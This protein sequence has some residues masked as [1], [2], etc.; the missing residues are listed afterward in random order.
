MRKI[1]ELVLKANMVVNGEYSSRPLRGEATLELL[2]GGPMK[3]VQGL[4]ILIEEEECFVYDIKFHRKDSDLVKSYGIATGC[5]IIHFAV[6]SQ[7]YCTGNKSDRFLMIMEDMV[8][9]IL[10]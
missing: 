7:N 1:R 8:A 5:Y 6:G 3:Y 4:P 10:F 2:P 9:T